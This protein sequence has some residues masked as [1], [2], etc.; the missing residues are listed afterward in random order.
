MA[1]RESASDED[2]DGVDRSCDVRRRVGQRAPQ[3]Y[4]P[5]RTGVAG[6][7]DPRSITRTDAPRHRVQNG[8]LYFC[9]STISASGVSIS[10]RQAADHLAGSGERASRT[11]WPASSAALKCPHRA[12]CSK[13]A[14]ATFMISLIATTAMSF[15]DLKIARPAIITT[16]AGTGVR[17]FTAYGGPGRREG[18]GCAAAQHRVR[19]PRTARCSSC[20]LGNHRVRRLQSRHQAMHRDPMPHRRSHF[21]AKRAP[22]RCPASAAQWAANDGGSRARRPVSR[23]LREATR[24][25]HR[26]ASQTLHHACPPHRGNPGIP[27]TAARRRSRAGGRT[28]A[29][30]TRFALRFADNVESRRS[31]AQT[32]DRDQSTTVARNRHAWRLAPVR[33]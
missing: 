8:A 15:A 24:L 2:R 32:R 7:S 27:A 31:A 12:A 5:D 13:I 26:A 28:A 14:A 30:P 16:V 4:N 10:L 17:R 23:A 19:D 20:R 29:G 25:P 33:V 9:D 6:Y 21:D 18:A 11:G 22:V 1:H 3:V